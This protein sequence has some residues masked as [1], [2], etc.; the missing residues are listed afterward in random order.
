MQSAFVVSEQGG[1]TSTQQRQHQY[2]ASPGRAVASMTAQLQAA[3][4]SPA[5]RKKD[6]VAQAMQ[7]QK[8]FED[9]LPKTEVK[10]EPGVFSVDVKKPETKPDIK[11]T[12]MATKSIPESKVVTAKVGLGS[13]GIQQKLPNSYQQ[14]HQLGCRTKE[15]SKIKEEEDDEGLTCRLCLA[16]YWYKRELHDHLKSVHSI[17]D[18]E[19]YDREEQEKKKRRQREEEQRRGH[20]IKRE[21]EEKVRGRGPSSSRGKKPGT[22][23]LTSPGAR[24]SQSPGARPSFQYRDGAFICDLC[25]ESFSDGNDMVTHWKSHVKKQQSEFKSA[26]GN[27]AKGKGRGR[28]RPMTKREYRS[29]S[30]EEKPRKRGPRTVGKS[31]GRSGGKSGGRGRAEKGKPRWTAYL[32]WSTRKRR[33]V[34][35]DHPDW[36]FAQIAKWIS[37]EWKKI[38]SDEKDELQKEAEEM[39][40]LG[41]R[42]LPRDDDGV[43]PERDTTDDDSDFEEGYRKKA[44]R[45]KIKQEKMEGGKD[46]VEDSEESDWEPEAD[47]NIKQRESRS[48][49]QRKRPSFFQE[50]ESQ[51]NNLDNILQEFEETQA[52][53]FG[54]PR[55]PKPEKPPTEKKPRKP[56]KPKE[57]VVDLE[58]EKLETEVLRSGRK[59]KVRRVIASFLDDDDDEDLGKG[60]SSDDDDFEPPPEEEIEKIEENDDQVEESDEVDEFDDDDEEDY[61]DIAGPKRDHAL[62]IKKRGRPKKILTDAEIEEATRA[63]LG[64]V[65]VIEITPVP[66]KTNGEKE[67]NSEVEPGEV[68][69]ASEDPEKGGEEADEEE[70]ASGEAQDEETKEPEAFRPFFV[71][72]SLE[73]ETEKGEEVGGEECNPLDENPLDDNPLGDTDPLNSEAANPLGGDYGSEESNSKQIPERKSTSEAGSSE[74]CAQLSEDEALLATVTCGDAPEPQGALLGQDGL[75]GGEAGLS[76]PQGGEPQKEMSEEDLLTGPAHNLDDTQYKADYADPNLD[77]IFK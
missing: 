49:R 55:L 1:S 69:R 24:Q 9:S 17:A 2:T 77:D 59:R 14:P 38:E 62:P 63:A 6:I 45:I 12:V 41:I 34:V 51:E 76:L 46:D 4:R 3:T 33:E 26:G 64:T 37:D 72:E 10:Q 58:E 11:P 74:K 56:R 16:S 71:N 67:K 13:K 73:E 60:A 52:K 70:G 61:D 42:K 39:N 5:E 28:G 20:G 29:D 35:V 36:T 75:G 40:E 31:G 32:L 47:I 23:K 30:E 18:P 7:E 43:D 27:R 21:R 19:K 8:I 48:G 44:K 15:G 57:P 54:K 22:I 53:E 65:P 66:R 50:F 68:V 25:K